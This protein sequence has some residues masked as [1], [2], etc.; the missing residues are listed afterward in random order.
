MRK[1][2]YQR[3]NNLHLQKKKKIYIDLSVIFELINYK[4]SKNM[5]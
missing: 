3:I 5:I 1:L 4:I 2:I